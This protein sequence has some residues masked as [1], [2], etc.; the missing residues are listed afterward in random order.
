MPTLF[1]QTILPWV[2][3]I[4]MALTAI[5]A[6][7]ALVD[8]GIHFHEGWQEGNRRYD[9]V[10]KNKRDCAGGQFESANMQ[11]QCARTRGINLPVAW[12]TA[13]HFVARHMWN[14]AYNTVQ[15][16]FM[17]CLLLI[18][19]SF[20]VFYCSLRRQGNAY[21]L[22][23]GVNRTMEAVLAGLTARPYPQSHVIHLPAEDI[24]STSRPKKQE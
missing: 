6:I 11:A 13:F 9:E 8:I 17:L 24:N 10:M 12:H 18:P 14:K 20:L 2:W 16:V 7:V 15:S 4:G 21:M 19:I 3:R 22:P 23:A 1:E 5:Y